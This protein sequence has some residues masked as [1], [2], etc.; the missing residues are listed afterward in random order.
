VKR[1]KADV[2]KAD[3]EDFAKASDETKE[4][5]RAELEPLYKALKDMIT[6]TL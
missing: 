2:S 3:P 6:A 5:I 4:A 1:I